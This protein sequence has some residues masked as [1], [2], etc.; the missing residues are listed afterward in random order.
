MKITYQAWTRKPVGPHA[1]L[2]E[3]KYTI[4]VWAAGV[5]DGVEEAKRYL[6]NDTDKVGDVIAIEQDRD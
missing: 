6:I 2:D 1:T 4:T 5:E 3:A